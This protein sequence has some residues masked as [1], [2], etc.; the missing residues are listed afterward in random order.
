MP[1]LT[2][3]GHYDGD[4][5][6]AMELHRRRMRHASEE[7]KARH[8]PNT[9]GA[10]SNLAGTRDIGNA[11][12]DQIVLVRSLLVLLAPEPKGGQS[13]EADWEKVRNAMDQGLPQTAIEHLQPIIDQALQDEDFPEAIKGIGLKIVLEGY[14][15]CLSD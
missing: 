3:T 12:R 14:I 15:R 1:I 10:L 4:Q 11:G 5:P 6:A 9:E 2:V 7:A 8:Y 13:R